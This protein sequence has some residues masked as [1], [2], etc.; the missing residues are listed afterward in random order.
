MTR[1][2][3]DTWDSGNRLTRFHE[4]VKV[5]EVC[6]GKGYLMSPDEGNDEYVTCSECDGK[7]EIVYDEM[8]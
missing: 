8:F 2:K 7:G 4:V 3:S 1:I 5:C 6:E